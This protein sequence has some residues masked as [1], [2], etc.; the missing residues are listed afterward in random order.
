MILPRWLTFFW[1]IYPPTPPINLFVISS[2]IFSPNYLFSLDFGMCY[3]ILTWLVSMFF[4]FVRLHVLGTVLRKDWIAWISHFFFV[5]LL[6]RFQHFPHWSSDFM[7]SYLSSIRFSYSVE[8]EVR[9]R[10]HMDEQKKS[11]Y[12]LM[13]PWGR[14]SS[15]AISCWRDMK[16]PKGV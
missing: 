6:M 4:S 16:F 13:L 2:S 9:S 5:V 11:L 3:G 8:T 14:R 10:C 7:N 1:Q 15:Y 12:G